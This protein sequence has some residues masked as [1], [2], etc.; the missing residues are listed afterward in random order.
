MISNNNTAVPPA[1]FPTNDQQTKENP[2]TSLLPS[3]QTGVPK[4]SSTSELIALTE[5][6]HS[7]NAPDISVLHRKTE[8]SD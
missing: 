5:T 6:L 3:T 4:P 8:A 1:L 2:A 7:Q